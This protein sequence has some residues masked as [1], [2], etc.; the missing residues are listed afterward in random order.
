MEK[1]HQQNHNDD[2]Q[3]DTKF[4]KKSARVIKRKSSL[5]T[6]SVAELNAKVFLFSFLVFVR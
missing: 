2:S 6:E 5:G 4:I 3:D 1:K